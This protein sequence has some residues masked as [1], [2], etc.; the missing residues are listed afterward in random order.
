VFYDVQVAA[1]SDVFTSIAAACRARGTWPVARV[2]EL[3]RM[4]RT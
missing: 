2:G 4:V 1:S 3:K